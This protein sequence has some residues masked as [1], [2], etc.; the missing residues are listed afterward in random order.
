MILD[1]G[2]LIG[3]VRRTIDLAAVI[4]SQ[5][6]ALPAVVLAEFRFGTHLDPDQARRDEQLAFLQATLRTTPIE[7][8]T[9]RIVPHHVELMLHARSQGRPRGTLDLI[10]AA[11]ARATRRTL[12]TTDARAG[13][14]DLPGVDARLLST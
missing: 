13:F 11:T 10:V 9:P 5:D 12:I 1:T 2:V 6:V 8:Y 4:R 7:D 14:D 3:A